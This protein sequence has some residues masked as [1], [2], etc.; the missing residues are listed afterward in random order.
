[1][2]H[3]PAQPPQHVAHVRAEDAAVAVAFVDDH[4]AQP[5]EE[6]RPAGVPGQQRAMQHVRGGQQVPGVAAR[7]GPLGVGRVAI[8]G[9]RLHPGQAERADRRELVGR[10]RLGGR[11]IQHS[12]ARQHRGE[13]RQQVAERLAR[14]RGGGDDHVPAGPG[15]VRGLRLVTPRSPDAAV[16]EGADDLVGNPLRPGHFPAG[17]GRDVLDVD[18]AARPRVIEQD[19]ERAVLG[20]AGGVVRKPGAGS[21][22]EHRRPGRGNRGEGRHSFSKC[23]IPSADTRRFCVCRPLGDAR[24]HDFV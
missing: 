23:D 1:M 22:R 15:V 14:S 7:P 24:R 5:A 21:C 13:R 8:E 6:P 9:G 4:V 10:E 11:D 19:A 17:P 20:P 2:G 16:R 18:R 3:H 12:V